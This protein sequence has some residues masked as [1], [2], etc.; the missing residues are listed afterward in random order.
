M[1][2]MLDIDLEDEIDFRS[3][4]ETMQSIHKK[5]VEREAEEIQRVKTKW[6]NRK[7][8]PKGI[9]QEKKQQAAVD[10]MRQS[11]RDIYRKLASALH[12]D[13]VQEQS[14][15]VRREKLMQRVN[16]AYAKKDLLQLLELQLEI[17][18]IDQ[19]AIDRI[20]DDQLQHYNQVLNE[21]L[22]RLQEEVIGIE[23]AFRMQFNLPPEPFISSSDQMV[24]KGLQQAIDDIQKNIID[25]QK[26][27]PL[28]KESKHLKKWLRKQF[29]EAYS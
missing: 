13:R 24:L 28:L 12:P 11:T 8:F 14:E 16:V 5:V 20:S 1:E 4:H 9:A 27:I 19:R 21:Q 2:E 23:Y 25:L 26:E 10:Q 18:Q 17:E 29:I 15:Q 22:S 7:K 3:P 6:Q